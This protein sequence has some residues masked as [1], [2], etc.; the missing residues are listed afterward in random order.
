MIVH[1]LF[2]ISAAIFERFAVIPCE[3]RSDC[4]SMDIKEQYQRIFHYCCGKISDRDIAED[5]TQETFLR[6]LEHPEYQGTGKEL[7]YLYTIARNLCIDEYRKVQTE[8]LPEQ[9]PDERVTDPGWADR[10]TVRSILESLPEEEREIITLRYVAELSV[11][12]IAGMYDVSWF[13]MNR[14]IKRILA[15]MRNSFEKEGLE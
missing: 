12:D 9:L 8:E 6:F 14:R 7:Q 10:L 15:K 13:A 5:V 3:G 11:A 1:K 4:L 2:T